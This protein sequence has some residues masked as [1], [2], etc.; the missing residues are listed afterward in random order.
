MIQP[1][2]QVPTELTRGRI[3]FG[4]PDGYFVNKNGLRINHDYRPNRPRCAVRKLKPYP[5]LRYYGNKECHVLMVCTFLRKP[6]RSIRETID[7]IDGNTLNYSVLN[8]RIVSDSINRRDAGFLRKLRNK[9]IDATMYSAPLLLR[10]FDRMADFKAHHSRTA[11]E[12]VT[13]TELLQ[14]LV[15]PEVRVD[16]P[17]KIM[18]YEMTHHCEC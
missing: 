15:S 7:H 12:K 1:L 3:V 6:D 2:R 11:Y 4:H 16:D 13:R 17:D 9:G 18:E 14:M 10:F 8:L 5:K